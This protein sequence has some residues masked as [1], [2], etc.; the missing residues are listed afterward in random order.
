MGSGVTLS[1][2]PP[3]TLNTGFRF[4]VLG[5]GQNPANLEERVLSNFQ[6][7]GKYGQAARPISTS[8]LHT[9]L[10]FHLWPINLVVYQGPL[11]D[12]SRESYS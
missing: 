8:R 3:E 9:L 4:W 6:K 5:F 11:G 1:L 10:R 12:C 2:W 7:Q